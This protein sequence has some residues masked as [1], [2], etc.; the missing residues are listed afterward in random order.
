MQYRVMLKYAVPCNVKVM[1]GYVPRSS[2]SILDPDLNLINGSTVNRNQ[3][4]VSNAHVRQTVNEAQTASTFDELE[5]EQ[6]L[7]EKRRYVI[8]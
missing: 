6:E 7:A 5:K 8:I 4:D 3:S 1:P 2:K